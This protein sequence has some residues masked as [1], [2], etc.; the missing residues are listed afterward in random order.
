MKRRKGIMVY[1]SDGCIICGKWEKNMFFIEIK[2]SFLGN[3]FFKKYFICKD[4]LK[5]FR[6]LSDEYEIRETV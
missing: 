5:P 6:K 2:K 3:L 4:C 1:P